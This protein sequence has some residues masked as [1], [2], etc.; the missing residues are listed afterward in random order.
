MACNNSIRSVLR[1]LILAAC[2]Y[3]IWDERN[4]RLFGN[5]KRDYK[6]VLFTII[7][8]IRMKLTSLKV[9]NSAQVAKV[10]KDW[11]VTLNGSSTS[12]ELM[13]IEVIKTDCY[14]ME[15]VCWIWLG[16]LVAVL[17]PDVVVGHLGDA[18]SVDPS[19]RVFV[20][21]NVAREGSF[22]MVA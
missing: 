22:S 11:Q 19:C 3:Y 13:K 5:Q 17:F 15:V 9:K 1:R 16:Y 21:G 4:K 6:T 12:E 8:H 7:N 14:I 20:G 2:V 18:M 10:N